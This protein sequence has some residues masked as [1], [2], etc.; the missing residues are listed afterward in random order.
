MSVEKDKKKLLKTLKS[1]AKHKG[2][3]VVWKLGEPTKEAKKKGKK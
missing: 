3:K 1:D 2:K